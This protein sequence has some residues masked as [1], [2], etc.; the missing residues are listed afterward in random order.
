LLLA[1][2]SDYYMFIMGGSPKP[3]CRMEVPENRDVVCFL[4]CMIPCCARI[5]Q[6]LR[7]KMRLPW[8]GMGPHDKG[9]PLEI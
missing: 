4:H 3:F 9:K 6:N 5:K 8:L 7:E 2:Y 1:N